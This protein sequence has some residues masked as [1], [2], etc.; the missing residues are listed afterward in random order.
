MPGEVMHSKSQINEIE[1]GHVQADLIHSIKSQCCR[2]AVEIEDGIQPALKVEFSLNRSDCHPKQSLIQAKLHVQKPVA[3]P[4]VE[5]YI[6]I[7]TIL[8]ITGIILDA[9]DRLGNCGFIQKIQIPQTC[10]H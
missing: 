6:N 1:D 8:R 10:R 4:A 2:T 5:D 3:I 7:F 9:S